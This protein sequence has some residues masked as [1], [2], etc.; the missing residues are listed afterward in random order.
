LDQSAGVVF[1]REAAR[2]IRRRYEVLMPVAEPDW[3]LLTLRFA[4]KTRQP[5]AKRIARPLTAETLVKICADSQLGFVIAKESVGFSPLQHRHTGV[6]N[7]WNLYD[8][9]TVRVAISKT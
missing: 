8:C 3:R 5:G 6:W 1:S 4:M 9:R 2:E 7:N